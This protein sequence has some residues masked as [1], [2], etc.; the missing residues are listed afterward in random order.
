MV[1]LLNKDENI[2]DENK[3]RILF[4]MSM[5]ISPPPYFMVKVKVNRKCKDVYRDMS[6][7][8]VIIGAISQSHEFG[9]RGL[10]T[11][12]KTCERWMSFFFLQWALEKGFS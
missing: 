7:E 12:R 8:I 3:V 6:Q 5:N 10:F 2:K 11:K 1:D 4:L 9:K